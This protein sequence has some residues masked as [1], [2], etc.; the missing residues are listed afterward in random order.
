MSRAALRNVKWRN[1]RLRYGGIAHKANNILENVMSTPGTRFQP[2]PA[3]NPTHDKKPV[4]V[5]GVVVVIALI[6]AIIAL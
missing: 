1:A 2:T 6:A 5:F 3:Y 4:V